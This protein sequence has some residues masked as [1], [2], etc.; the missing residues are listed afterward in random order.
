MTETDTKQPVFDD[1]EAGVFIFACPHCREIT[2]VLKN[3]INCQ[4]FRHASHFVWLPWTPHTFSHEYRED[5][6]KIFDQLLIPGKATDIILTYVGELPKYVPTTQVNPHLSKA[7]CD[8]LVARGLVLGCAK[9]YYFH[10][11]PQ[12]NFVDVCDYI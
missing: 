4:I 2:Q 11:S 8:D 10:F 12:G 9:P 3:Q 5:V 1:E 7:M 6:A